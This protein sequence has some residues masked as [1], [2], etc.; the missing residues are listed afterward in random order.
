MEEPQLRGLSW[1]AAF[2]SNHRLNLAKTV[3]NEAIAKG[4]VLD[5]IGTS[6]SAAHASKPILSKR[7]Q[8]MQ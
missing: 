3:P 6:H 2:L 4:G 7:S 8:I 5:Y 1:E